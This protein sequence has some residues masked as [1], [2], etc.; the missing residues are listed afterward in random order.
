[1]GKAK[2]G[3]L[4][5]GSGVAAGAAAHQPKKHRKMH[6]FSRLSTTTT[7]PPPLGPPAIKHDGKDSKTIT[8]AIT[9]Q[10]P[11]Q[12]RRPIVP[13]GKKDRILL[14]GEGEFVVCS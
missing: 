6:T 13:F 8:G 3:R 12:H 2:K 1:M 11:K 5:K 7:T 14:V 4:Q 9:S 10:Q